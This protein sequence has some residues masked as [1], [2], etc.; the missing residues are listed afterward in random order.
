MRTSPP[1]FR[2]ILLLSLVVALAPSRGW[3]QT[4]NPNDY[5]LITETGVSFGRASSVVSG[6][7]TVSASLD[8]GAKG[9][10]ADRQFVSGDGAHV[11][12]DRSRLRGP[13]SV[14]GLFSNDATLDQNVAVRA[15]CGPGACSFPVPVFSVYPE[16]AAFSAGTQTITVPARSTMTLPP[17]DYGRLR[18]RGRSTVVFTGGVY[19][20]S[21]IKS[22]RVARLL[23]AA[24]ATVNVTGRM[25]L[26]VAN[27][28]GPIGPSPTLQDIL[29][30]VAGDQVRLRPRSTV[31]ARIW[32]PDAALF[33]G[34]GGLIKG[35]LVAREAKIGR[36]TVLQSGFPIGPF[37]VRTNTPT[38]T[39]TATNTSPPTDTPTETPVPTATDTFAPTSTQTPVPTPTDTLV[40]TPTETLVPTATETFVPTATETLVPTA[41]ETLVPTATDTPVPTTTDTPTDDTPTPTQPPPTPTDTV[42]ATATST[43]APNTATSTPTETFTLVPTATH[44]ITFTPVPT[45]TSTHTLTFTAVPTATQTLTFTMVPTVT[46]TVTQ[47]FTA[48]PTATKTATNTA[49][50]PTST[51]TT[52]VCDGAISVGISSFEQVSFITQT[53]A[54]TVNQ[55]GGGAPGAS[56]SVAADFVG[57]AGTQTGVAVSASSYLFG[58]SVIAYNIS[59]SAE[60]GNLPSVALGA[61]TDITFTT[62]GSGGP[63]GTDGDGSLVMSAAGNFITIGFGTPICASGCQPRTVVVFT[64]TAG[65]GVA[66]VELLDGGVPVAS[67]N[68]STPGGAVKSAIGGIAFDVE[69]IAFE[70]VRITRVSGTV[71]LDAVAVKGSLTC[72]PGA[73]VGALC[74]DGVR[75]GG[76]ECDDGDVSSGDGCSSDCRNE[77]EELTIGSSRYCTLSQGGWH[78]AG[79]AP[80]LARAPEILPATIGGPDYSTTIHTADALHTYLPK[81]GPPR[82]LNPGERNFYTA[83][84]VTNDGSGVLGGQAMALTLAV[85]LSATGEV[86]DTFGSLLLPSQAFC[87]QGLLAGDDGFIGTEDDLLDPGSAISGPWTI[88]ATVVGTINT[89]SDLLVMSNQYLRG[90]QSAPSISEVNTALDT[91]NNAFDACRQAVPCP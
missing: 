1:L 16:L 12:S 36:G 24:P 89:V 80:F 37:E 67:L 40:P 2:R 60:P 91:L 61:P 3:A 9:F 70:H 76:E 72:S 4:E 62:P 49:A 28:V 13:A 7:V 65:G 17:G 15:P 74:G 78:G 14:Y 47:T 41:T 30:N 10:F 53:M 87:T 81:G 59:G 18:L 39:P 34:F 31:S 75:E 32:A 56:M 84:Q 52:A 38:I 64:D 23:F 85:N 25:R 69:N 50:P 46:R 20:F 43:L 8:D 79:G 63:D 42:E 57:T 90:G 66:L 44:T 35:Q 71:E 55:I 27:V 48:V 86:Y 26:G 54:G 19:T 33:I 82:A 5:V 51:P 22:G 6:N 68:A 21:E 83:S 58:S 29:F 88:P 11:V 73:K 77:Y 45:V